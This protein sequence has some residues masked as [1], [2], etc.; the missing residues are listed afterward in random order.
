MASISMVAQQVNLPC[1]S[2][3]S[4]PSSSSSAQDGKAALTIITNMKAAST[5]CDN[6]ISA[7][8]SPK[9]H[10]LRGALAFFFTIR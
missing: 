4:L 9:L 8:S 6:V 5:D 10:S 2:T 3:K 7:I 1:G